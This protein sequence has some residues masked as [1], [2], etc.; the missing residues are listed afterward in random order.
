MTTTPDSPPGAA[1]VIP[2]LPKEL[3]LDVFYHSV[4]ASLDL[5]I[6]LA[7]MFELRPRIVATNTSDWRSTRALLNLDLDF[8]ALVG[9]ESY[10]EFPS[11]LNVTFDNSLEHATSKDAV[12]NIILAKFKNLNINI[13]I[14]M[15]EIGREDTIYGTL[16]MPYIWNGWEWM[17]QRRGFAWISSQGQPDDVPLFIKL[18]AHQIGDHLRDSLLTRTLDSVWLVRY[19]KDLDKAMRTLNYIWNPRWELPFEWNVEPLEDGIRSIRMWK[20]HI[21][22]W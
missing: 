2:V 13:P 21:Q 22:Y 18:M 6:S 16:R 12:S 15:T 4:S 20:E 11:T 9:K 10:V 14:C 1:P 3:L 7:H 17:I 19:R 8:S 5:T